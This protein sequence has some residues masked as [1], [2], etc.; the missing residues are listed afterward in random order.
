MKISI[1]SAFYPFRGGISQFNARLF[2]E[3]E[4]NHEVKAFTFKK[5]YPNFLFPGT[6]QFV[7]EN[8]PSDKI[9]AERIVS[10]FN[11]FTYFSAARRLQKTNPSLFIANYWM[12]FFGL[13]LG[14]F[15]RK[16]NKETQKIAIIHNLIPHEPRFF[17][18]WLNSYFLKRYNGFIVM[19]DA[20]RDDL[21]KSKPNARYMQLNHP[22]YDHFGEKLDVEFAR[23]KLGVAI[24]KKTLLFF[25]L[26]RDYKGLDLL[27]DAFKL[28][29]ESYQLMIVGEVYSNLEVY[30]KQIATS[31]AK[32]RI[33]FINKYIPD[34]AVNSYFSAAD[35]CVLPYRT[36]TQSGITATSF[37]FN[38]PILA[39]NVGGFKSQIEAPGLGIVVDA[40][41]ALLI[42]EG[43]EN[44]FQK[45]LK[46]DFETSIRVE[47]SKNTWENY[48]QQLISF[49]QELH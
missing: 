24:D 15:A 42:K 5:Q 33:Y 27:I 9:P 1:F 21:L 18:K 32:E 19:S 48:A 45:A 37:H 36:A 25:G 14:F 6:T 47:K 44:Y 3:L 30:Q 41:D 38:I 35:L 23:K 29:D 17:D 11:P 40:P 16:L 43:I 34:S 26:I 39:T 12:S 31:G 7:D 22:W 20:V 49:S 28:L 2:R 8:D 13:F 46:V 10:T 4:K